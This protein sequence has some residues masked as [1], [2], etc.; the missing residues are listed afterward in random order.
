MNKLSQNVV[1][2]LKLHFND[3][4]DKLYEEKG[5]SLQEICGW[6]SSLDA[7]LE[8]GDRAE[9]ALYAAEDFKRTPQEDPGLDL[10]EKEMTQPVKVQFYCRWFKRLCWNGCNVLYRRQMLEA[11]T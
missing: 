7:I 9:S 5:R 10:P 2:E 1:R 4:F 8:A 3:A 11:R 6:I